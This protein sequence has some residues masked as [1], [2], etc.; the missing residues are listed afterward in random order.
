M[1]DKY[2]EMLL[3]GYIEG[4]LTPE[5]HEKAEALL[6]SDPAL[7]QLMQGLAVDREAVRALP[8][9]APTRPLVD[10]V[11]QQLERAMLLDPTRDAGAANAKAAGGDAGR[12]GLR[13][14]A[15][16]GLAAAVV[17]LVG[18]GVTTLVSSGLLRDANRMIAL[19][20]TPSEK[21]GG[22]DVTSTPH[23]SETGHIARRL[24]DSSKGDISTED[25]AL[26]MGDSDRAN[27][28]E[29]KEFDPARLSAT[30]TR[31]RLASAG[32][33]KE[34]I[35]SFSEAA[36]PAIFERADAE[37]EGSV[38]DLAIADRSAAGPGHTSSVSSVPASESEFAA[39]ASGG[40]PFG[41][42]GGM[43]ERA[44]TS[45]DA[46]A[47][48][49]G[50][51]GFSASTGAD[52]ADGGDAA[53]RELVAQ[54][55]AARFADLQQA[56]VQI[57]VSTDDVGLTQQDLVEWAKLQNAEVVLLT[58]ARAGVG[59]EYR[60][61]VVG[62]E[63]GGAGWKWVGG[64]PGRTLDPSDAALDE[65]GD[66]ARS[67]PPTPPSSPS[68]TSLPSDAAADGPPEAAHAPS[69][70]EPE[71]APSHRPVKGPLARPMSADQ[72]AQDKQDDATLGRVPAGSRGQAVVLAL[73][74]DQVEGLVVHLNALRAQRQ[75]ARVEPAEA[76]SLEQFAA[77]PMFSSGLPSE[78]SD[79]D[80][81]ERQAVLDSATGTAGRL[82]DDVNAGLHAVTAKSSR[83]GEH[84]PTRDAVSPANG[85]VADL[86]GS[87]GTD[88][89][90]EQSGEVAGDLAEFDWAGLLSTHLPKRFT[91]EIT[92]GTQPSP[93]AVE[94]TRKEGLGASSNAPSSP[95]REQV[96]LPVWIQD[97]SIDEPRT[98]ASLEST[99]SSP[100]APSPEPSS[101]PVDGPPAAE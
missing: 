63:G 46:T 39:A 79:D 44:E 71:D 89:A 88:V 28:L 54:F 70:R 16:G 42:D 53:P 20:D 87:R 35:D 34:N 23:K 81:R 29:N 76:G 77:S 64:M 78:H 82:A 99:A 36:G 98:D 62:G 66:A 5:D 86:A 31:E 68:A 100:E 41:E 30:A 80:R 49:A 38:A 4:D 32:S 95:P 65:V 17:L 72:P 21:G 12:G 24:K 25:T 90:K 73:D 91:P 11:T 33:G 61:D 6:H 60:R 97:R 22:T 47:R 7:A 40:S 45:R 8:R 14:V 93:D 57:Q 27:A 37:A 75:V 56:P 84:P 59:N 96:L 10:G 18:L 3:L 92:P 19:N 26:V 48:N 52:Q 69:A 2:D 67:T 1:P 85:P 43:D 50:R 9:E 13:Y 51:G 101:G 74:P 58:H 83:P 94:E 55:R 15:Y